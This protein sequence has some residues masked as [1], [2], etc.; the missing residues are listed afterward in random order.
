[1]SAVHFVVNKLFKFFK[2]LVS[3][4]FWY[5]H[6]L[7]VNFGASFEI[8][9]CREPLFNNL[10]ICYKLEVQLLI[11][12]VFSLLEEL[13][14]ISFWQV[15]SESTEKGTDILRN[16]DWVLVIIYS[17]NK[18]ANQL[19]SKINRRIKTE[20]ISKKAKSLNRQKRSIIFMLK[21]RVTSMN[22]LFSTKN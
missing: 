4:G 2:T 14:N 1:M 8:F 17:E 12:T 22:T 6:F 16:S 7:W 9:M 3:I 5:F 10:L 13:R 18:Q 20:K 21:F 15:D 19:F 11:N